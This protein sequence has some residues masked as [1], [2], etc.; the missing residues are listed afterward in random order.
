[1]GNHKKIIYDICLN[2]YK[3]VQFVCKCHFL[4]YNIVEDEKRS[5]ICI[6]TLPI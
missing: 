3:T 1:M 2:I 6:P 5:G 4:M